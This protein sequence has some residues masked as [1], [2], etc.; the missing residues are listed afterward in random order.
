MLLRLQF[1][2]VCLLGRVSVVAALFLLFKLPYTLAWCCSCCIISSVT[3]SQSL[4]S[5]LLEAFIC[6]HFFVFVW[7]LITGK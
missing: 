3:L 6:L 7:L 2:A 1:V 5:V 4:G